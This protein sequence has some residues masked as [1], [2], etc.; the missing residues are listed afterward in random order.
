MANGAP[1][2]SNG[3]VI[4]GVTTVTTLD[5]NGDLDVDGHL[6]VDNVSVSGISTFSDAVRIVKTAGPLLELTTNTG[7][8]DATLR[9]S[10]GATGSTTNGGGMFYSGADNKLHITCGTNSTT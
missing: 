9:L 2:V 3:L 6:N 10:E 7:A 1:T 5:L 8:A 4:S